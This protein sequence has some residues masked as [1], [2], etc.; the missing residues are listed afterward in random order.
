MK[1]LIYLFAVSLLL[2]AGAVAKNKHPGH[3][4]AISQA[5]ADSLTRQLAGT[6]WTSPFGKPGRQWFSLNADGTATAGWHDLVGSWKVVAPL[7][8][9]LRIT[10][11]DINGH[12]STLLHFDS[13]LSH[14]GHTE[15][16]NAPTQAMRDKVANKNVA[17]RAPGSKSASDVESAPEAAATPPISPELQASTAAIVKANSRNL[18]FVSGKEG[19][20]SGFIAKL[21]EANYLVTNAHV[22]AGI[23]GAA[24]KT[25]EGTVV[26]GGKPSVAVGEDIFRMAMPPGG[27]PLAVMQDVGSNAGIGD[28]VV[29]L[30][31]AE[32]AGVINTIVGKIVGIGPNLVEVSAPFVPGN[33]GSP[34]IHV[35]SGQV[36]GVATFT[37]TRTY[38]ATTGEKMK[39][40]V[41]RWFG[42]RLDGVKAWQPVNWAA[43][44]A[45]AA[46][47]RSIETLSN[48]LDDF[49]NDLAENNG[50]VTPE[51]HTNPV[52]RTQIDRWLA[53][54]GT[55]MSVSDQV[56]ENASFLSFLKAACQRDVTAA[57]RDMTYDYF[58]RELADQQAAR[59]A[60]SKAFEEIIKDIQK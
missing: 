52:I 33:S 31:N 39:A 55:Q 25:L 10:G 36:I 9:E 50:V 59:N 35:K 45:Q 15:R 14:G 57:G 17:R 27:Q 22:I 41:V 20:G 29:V 54:K 60:M 38:N 2:P 28:D 32:G 23:T 3:Q 1:I 8:I 16:I 44:D 30:G 43:F 24:F 26:P 6:F 19:D 40:P 37:V 18:V 42:Y 7:T 48:D 58:V 11:H 21:G 56:E 12:A 5:E 53:S 13:S 34:I 49:F 4:A 46:E 51:R 47:M